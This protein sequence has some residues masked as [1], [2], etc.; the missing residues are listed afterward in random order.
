MA[1]ASRTQSPVKRLL[2]E[3]QSYQTEPNEALAHLGPISDDELLHWTAVMRGVPDTA[4]EGQSP[5][6]F[7]RYQQLTVP[8]RSMA[9]RHSNTTQLPTL[10]TNSNIPHANLPPKRPLY[11]RRD[12]SRLA[13]NDLESDL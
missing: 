11:H 13:E 7:S 6:F 4:Y 2:N 1:S 10:G 5:Y 3:L 8:R 12:M 9:P